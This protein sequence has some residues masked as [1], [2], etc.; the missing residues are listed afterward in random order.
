M[1]ILPVSRKRFCRRYTHGRNEQDHESIDFT[2]NEIT[3]LANFPLSKRLRTLLCARNR[4]SSLQASLAERIP[5]LSTLVLTQ[6][7]ISELADLEPLRGFK[8]LIHLTLVDNP[9]T[10]KEVRTLWSKNLKK[11]TRTRAL[12][13]PELPLLHPVP[14]PTDPLPRLPKSQRR[15]TQQSH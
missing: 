4:I 3:T 8:H 1:R 15:R 7:N 5:G 10:S 12:T 6:N 2:D 14:L 13:K 11:T 9:V